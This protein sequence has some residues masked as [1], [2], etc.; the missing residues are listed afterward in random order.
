VFRGIA[1]VAEETLVADRDV[2]FAVLRFCAAASGFLAGIVLVLFV[3]ADPPSLRSRIWR[4][5]VA[6]HGDRLELSCA[7]SHDVGGI[8]I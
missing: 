8:K 5:I 7:V 3:T 6:G 4:T 1:R 2:E